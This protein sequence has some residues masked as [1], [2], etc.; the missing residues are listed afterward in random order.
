MNL[1]R[2]ARRGTAEFW[3]G[4]CDVRQC[5]FS[6]IR[7]HDEA[8]G[9]DIGERDHFGRTSH[10]WRRD[11]RLCP[12]SGLPLARHHS[13]VLQE[14]ISESNK[15]LLSGVFPQFFPAHWLND[16]PDLLFSEF[17]SRI[18]VGYVDRLNG[19]Y[20]Y[21]MR[22]AFEQTG[23]TLELLHEAALKNLDALAELE[24]TVGRTPGGSEA[25]LKETEDNFRAV[26][27]LLPRVH[28]Q[29]AR[30]LGD[31][32]FV[33]IPC[34]DWFMCW[35]RTQADDWQSRN[36]AAALSDFLDDDYNL[37]PDI[38]I[39]TPEGFAVHLPQEPEAEQ[40]AP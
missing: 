24:V 5:H 15:D 7:P 23:L 28:A 16:A 13:I 27:L 39:R 22:S 35:S 33:S 12:L 34:R 2:I 14:M 36:Q 4:L 19:G 40:A 10:A 25:F 29:L 20:S 21:I 3:L 37:T 18:R 9:S 32:Y 8:S 38:L 1:L 6:L 17:P 30:E 31:E 26:R 11:S